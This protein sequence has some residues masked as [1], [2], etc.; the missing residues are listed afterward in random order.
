MAF[1]WVFEENFETGAEGRFTGTTVDTLGKLD[2]PGPQD[3]LDVPPYLGGYAM[4]VNLERGVAPAYVVGDL[5]FN[6]ANGVTQYARIML[7]LSDDFKAPGVNDAV[8]IFRLNSGAGVEEAAIGIV[9]SDK[10]ELMIA[11]R[12]PDYASGAWIRGIEVNRNEWLCLEITAA[13]V[14]GAL[15]ELR[16]HCNGSQVS[17]IGM[18]WLT[19]TS[20]WMGAITQTD[21][22]RGTLYFDSILIDEDRLVAPQILDP[23]RLD[24][25]TITLTKT[26]YAFVG[27]GEVVC[28]TLIAMGTTTSDHVAQLYDTDRL[29]VA[30]HDL[31]IALKAAVPESYE[32]KGTKVFK[33]G[34]YC[35]LSGTS[36]ATVAPS[37]IVQLG[38]VTEY[39]WGAMGEEGFAA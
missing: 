26:G 1:P 31:K 38:A 12:N 13:S 16:V 27:P 7:R 6:I 24:G 22:V 5:S 9:R 17:A 2:F 3:D 37:L 33:R 18:T 30:H 11:V 19:L 39:G 14:A 8:S 23:R 29:P 25:E 20:F 36:S 10:G 34:C 4:R 15:S 32:S 28:T 21:D 35:V